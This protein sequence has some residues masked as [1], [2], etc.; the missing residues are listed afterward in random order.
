MLLFI[1]LPL[2]ILSIAQEKF[3]FIARNSEEFVNAKPDA[4]IRNVH[5]DNS[6]MV[7]VKKSKGSESYNVSDVWGFRSRNGKEYRIFGGEEYQVLASGNLCIYAH[8]VIEV[9][10]SEGYS[11]PVL[12]YYFSRRIYGGIC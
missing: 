2:A 8:P 10:M 7:I 11:Y 3:P 12:K 9:I 6:N 4:G 1:V 5:I